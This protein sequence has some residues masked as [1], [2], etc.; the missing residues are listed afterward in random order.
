MDTE[1]DLSNHR[2]AQAEQCLKEA[3]LLYEYAGYK[4]AANRAYYCVLHS[5]RSLLALNKVDL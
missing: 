2:L 4:G 1:R 5:M 3:K